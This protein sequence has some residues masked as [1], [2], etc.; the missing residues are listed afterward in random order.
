MNTRTI[1]ANRV[2]IDQTFAG[3]GE[4]ATAIQAS[5]SAISDVE[6]G[7][8]A[9]AALPD[10]FLARDESFAASGGAVVIGDETVGKVQVRWA[11]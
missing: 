1:A 2:L 11:K 10:M 9:V 4:N 3:I 7:L 8:A 6:E 5:L